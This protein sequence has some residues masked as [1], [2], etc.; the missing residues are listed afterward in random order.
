[1][2]QPVKLPTGATPSYEKSENC[3]ITGKIGFDINSSAVDGWLYSSFI[4]HSSKKSIDH[5]FVVAA[6]KHNV[7]QYSL[8]KSRRIPSAFLDLQRNL[9]FPF[10]HGAFEEVDKLWGPNETT[11][12]IDSSERANFSLSDGAKQ[13]SVGLIVFESWFF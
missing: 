2:A 6:S 8:E 3:F 13:S 5:E 4:I 1:M 10:S 7:F 9:I 11:H 12:E